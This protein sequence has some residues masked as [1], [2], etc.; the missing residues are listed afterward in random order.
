AESGRILA[1][2]RSTAPEFTRRLPGRAGDGRRGAPLPQGL[3]ADVRCLAVDCGRPLGPQVSEDAI[4]SHAGRPK[5]QRMATSKPETRRHSAKELARRTTE[6][7]ASFYGPTGALFDK[8]WR[9][10][11][12]ERIAP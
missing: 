4:R 11:D 9:L 8:A 7:R 12:I 5:G 3:I 2:S 1:A 6:R 10:P